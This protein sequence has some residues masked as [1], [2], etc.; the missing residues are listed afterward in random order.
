MLIPRPIGTPDAVG[1]ESWRGTAG[2]MT[3]ARMAPILG[4]PAAIRMLPILIPRP[5]TAMVRQ[6]AELLESQNLLSRKCD[7]LV[8]WL[9]IVIFV[10]SRDESMF[11]T[12]LGL[13][14]GKQSFSVVLSPPAGLLLC[15]AKVVAQGPDVGLVARAARKE[16]DEM[17]RAADVFMNFL[18]MAKALSALTKLGADTQSIVDHSSFKTTAQS[19]RAAVLRASQSSATSQALLQDLS[20]G[21]KLLEK[22][23]DSVQGRAGFRHSECLFQAS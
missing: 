20:P 5:T 17:K 8:T 15:G 21:G 19:L 23:L 14:A 7:G 10:V 1:T 2:S 3:S 4:P 6:P 22:T 9:V 18:N 13:M 16:K 12:G 11:Q